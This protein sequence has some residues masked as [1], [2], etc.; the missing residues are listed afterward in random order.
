MHE[1]SRDEVG[2]VQGLWLGHGTY[3]VVKGIIEVRLDG[4]FRKGI[5]S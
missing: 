5:E 2:R 3:E 4:K 1:F